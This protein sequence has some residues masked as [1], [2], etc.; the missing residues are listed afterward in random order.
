MST[1][2]T[3]GTQPLLRKTAAGQMPSSDQL[4]LLMQVTSPRTWIALAAM[5]ALVAAAIAWAFVGTIPVRVT[6]TGVLI[7]PGEVFEVFV[8]APGRITDVLVSEDDTV[9][10]GQ[11]LAHVDESSPVLAP[12][13]GRVVDVKLERGAQARQDATLLSIEASGTRG[14]LQAIVY[15]RP[16]S[17]RHVEAGMPAQVS[18]ATLPREEFGFIIGTVTHVSEFPAT[19]D[20]MMRVLENRG[21]V[22]ELSANGPPFAV[23]VGLEPNP[24]APGRFRWSTTT[25]DAV[26]VHGGT[27]C[28]V[29]ITVREQRPVE[30]ILPALR[31]SL[32]L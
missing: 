11:V 25:G 23:Y 9:Q 1:S 13:A 3:P 27:Q 4:D 18:P 22:Q 24:Q 31:R 8:H 10:A 14:R 7:R 12:Y 5:G 6:A 28:E 16:V 29:T 30:L 15:T 17:G 2:P 32:G 20:A 19:A 26:T 21:L